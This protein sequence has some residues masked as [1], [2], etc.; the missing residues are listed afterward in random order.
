MESSNAPDTSTKQSTPVPAPLTP[1]Q[2]KEINAARKRGIVIRRAIRVATID[3]WI[4]ALM[5]ACSLACGCFGIANLLVGIPLAWV[6]FNAFKG[7]A[8]LRRFDPK[9]PT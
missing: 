3:A 7:A 8:G 9:A 5:A 1:E 2:I 4:S 6:A